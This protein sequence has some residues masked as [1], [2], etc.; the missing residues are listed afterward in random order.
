VSQT[1]APDA[2]DADASDAL[3]RPAAP[4]A[5][6]PA[7]L[8][9]RMA[10]RPGPRPAAAAAP[11]AVPAPH[12]DEVAAAKAAEFG[13]VGDD[14][15]VSVVEASGERV[16][17]QVPDASTSD[18]LALYVRRYLDLEAKVVLFEAR[19][20]ATDLS[21]KE[22][23]QTLAKLADEL[24]EP[25][26]VGDLDGLRARLDSLREPAEQ[27]IAALEA[28]RAAA[29][30]QALAE[31]TA[32]IEQA[33]AIASTDP[34]RMQWRP[35]GEQLRD[36]LE[37]WKQ[38]QRS[39]PRLDR[40]S[41]DGLWKR[42]SHARTTFDRERRRH[43]SEL[44]TRTAEAKAQKEALVAE[45][46]ALATSTDWG[47][48]A[49]AYRDLMARWKTAGRAS[50]SVDD[51]LWAQFRAAQDQ[52]F[53]ARDAQAA[54]VDAEYQANLEVKLQILA[55]AEALLPVSDV[56]AAR[57]ALRSIQSRWESA[58]RVP[59]ADFPRIEAR[60]RAV[61]GAVRDHE[62]AHWRRSNPEMKA[63][64]EGMLSQLYDAVAGLERDLADAEAAGNARKVKELNEALQARRA[65]LS[66]IEQTA[67]EHH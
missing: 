58:G 18:A 46:Q 59:R 9:A 23:E 56:Q 54:H 11:V 66:Q 25:A 64:A 57:K 34:A 12:L 53:N 42:F 4:A 60:L 55:E 3:S 40:A 48:T 1:P 10:P 31:R 67:S 39:G 5:P 21:A 37:Q 44:E 51:A 41:E 7:A 35:A 36:L 30:A 33:E 22:I 26:A 27:R 65:W 17:G 14:G 32:I 45:A 61:E 15:T 49:A 38:A 8:A 29:R 13:R 52:F 2:P 62:S 16:V 24:T 20:M 47:A 50:R 43:F 19:L 28:E 6:S 63:R